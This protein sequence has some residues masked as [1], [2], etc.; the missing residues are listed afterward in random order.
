MISAFNPKLTVKCRINHFVGSS[1]PSEELC[2]SY[3]SINVHNSLENESER[4]SHR[5]RNLPGVLT[6]VLHNLEQIH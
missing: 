5:Q 4:P 6:S 2:P 3:L 1:K